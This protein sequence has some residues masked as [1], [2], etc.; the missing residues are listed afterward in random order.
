MRQK[1]MKEKMDKLKQVETIQTDL[2]KQLPDKSSPEY[3]KVK[4]LMIEQIKL[5]HKYNL[6]KQEIISINVRKF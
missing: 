2:F 6:L 5:I 1:E 3:E 4:K